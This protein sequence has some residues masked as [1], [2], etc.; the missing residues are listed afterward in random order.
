M[1]PSLIPSLYPSLIP[2]VKPS[3]EPSNTPSDVPSISNYPSISSLPSLLP[4]LMPSDIPSNYPSMSP[5]RTS[6]QA[7][8]CESSAGVDQNGT[9]HEVFVDQ[10]SSSEIFLS[11]CLDK[12]RGIR[13]HTGCE[14]S[15]GSFKHCYVH[16]EPVVQGS[17]EGSNVVCLPESVTVDCS[18]GANLE[19]MI[20]LDNHTAETSWTFQRNS[21][22]IASISEGQYSTNLNGT[23]LYDYYCIEAGVEYTWVISDS[24]G[25]GICCDYGSGK[26]ELKL[27]GHEIASGSDFGFFA[28]YS[29]NSRRI[30]ATSCK[31]GYRPCLD[32]AKNGIAEIKANSCNGGGYASCANSGSYSGFA[33][34]EEGSCNGGIRT[35]FSNGV[36]GI[37]IIGKNSCNSNS[38][39]FAD[40]T[41][42]DNGVLN[43]EGRIGNGSCNAINA[44]NNNKGTIAD[45]CC[46][47]NGACNEN[48]GVIEAGTTLCDYRISSSPSLLPTLMPSDTP[49][50]Y[51]SMSPSRTSW[52]AGWCE[53]SAGVDQNG[54][55]HEVFV[56][57]DSSSEIFLSDCLDKCRGIR[58]HT[59]CEASLGSF[60][61]CYVHM[62][63]VVQGS[64]EG[65]NVVCL[66]ESVTVD[67]SGGANLEIMITLDN[68]TAETSW[69]FQRNSTNIASISEGQYSTNLNGTSLYDYYCIEAGV[70]YTWVISDSSGDG[71]CCDYGSG[72]YE[73]KLNGHE[74][75]S[76]SDFGF[77]AN[78][79]VNS[80]RIDATSCKT[81]YRP[82]LDMAKNGIAEI[83]ANS[84]NGGGYA[85]CAN[86]G[87]YSGF[88]S[89]EEGSCNGG[90]R[91]CFSNGVLGIGIIGKNSCNSN[92][93]S[94]ADTT[95]FDNGVLNKEG[96]IGNGS[97]NAIN[98]C[99]NNKGTIADGCCNYNGACNENS[100]V[101]EA[102][103][104][105]C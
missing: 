64:G 37:G 57:Q 65:S 82:C 60:K 67:C 24:S 98:A 97:C 100:G 12:C 18:G 41:C 49:S 10:D 7:G 43:K 1:I 3:I 22:N 45:G 95:C 35:C 61:H 84:C 90:I 75:A 51:P 30:D 14:A 68:H 29:V 78:Y 79:S 62:E 52:Q 19:I 39:S 103:S 93:T 55:M 20:T 74:I 59:G 42:F 83:K 101:I 9:M 86:S 71:I 40:T 46:N 58:G 48:S 87:S 77:F 102:G 8:W 11:D 80:R 33:S 85:S 96:R 76:G 69:T 104:T 6:W 73:L 17:G 92:S 36:L 16:M 5:S 34:I 89:I 81:G 99:N 88:A 4:T 56:D 50:N 94:F 47:Y 13:G 31:T 23:S 63:P 21:T 54:T 27:N 2:S 38:T 53:S 91:T 15:L 105:L 44:C 25:D 66:P 70:E 26:Y 32:M 72:K 28:N